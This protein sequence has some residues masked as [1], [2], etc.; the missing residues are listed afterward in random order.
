MA[1]NF[2]FSHETDVDHVFMCSVCG[3]VIGF[4]KPGLGTPNAELVGETLVA[5]PI[6]Y[7]Y[8]GPCIEETQ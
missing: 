7:E 1:H 2:V 8:V 6:A 4:N 5:P 3:I